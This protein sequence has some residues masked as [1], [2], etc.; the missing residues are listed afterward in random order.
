[1]PT[2]A[3]ARATICK[4]Q[5]HR[6]AGT[7]DVG[8]H[9]DSRSACPSREAGPG[10]QPG[11]CATNPSLATRASSEF[12]HAIAVLIH[13]RKTTIHGGTFLTKVLGCPLIAVQSTHNM[14]LASRTAI[15]NGLPA[16]NILLSEHAREEITT[17]N[18]APSHSIDRANSTVAINLRASQLIC[19]WPCCTDKEGNA[20]SRNGYFVGQT[21]ISAMR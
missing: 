8:C 7:S 3:E 4:S 1:M 5:T 9:C 10:Y 12:R 2:N 11:R 13:L 19:F 18:P 20:E 14:Q 6:V 17:K 21:P 16:V 15:P